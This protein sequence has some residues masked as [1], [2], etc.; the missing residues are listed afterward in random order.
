MGL[1][2]GKRGLVVGIANDHSYAYFIAQSLLEHGATC[3]FTHLPGD[4]MNRRVGKAIDQLGVP[5]PWLESMDAGKDDDLDRVFG[6]IGDDFG[7][8][9][10][11]VHSIAFAAR[12]IERSGRPASRLIS[13]HVKHAGEAA[14]DDLETVLGEL[15]ALGGEA[16]LREK[17]RGVFYLRSRAFL[18]FHEDPGGFY[19]D[20]WT[21][22]PV[23]AALKVAPL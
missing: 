8:I 15:R 12:R 21:W 4:K 17:K 22:K 11:L 13:R 20:L 18:H 23:P 10:F 2:D 1:M 9:D 6:K 16:G 3:L 14:L 7:S 5:K 19:A